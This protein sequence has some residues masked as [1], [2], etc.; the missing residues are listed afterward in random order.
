[1]Y[2]CTYTCGA[3]NASVRP[4]CLRVSHFCVKTCTDKSSLE[5]AS[6]LVHKPNCCFSFGPQAELECGFSPCCLEQ[7]VF[8]HGCRSPV[9]VSRRWLALEFGMLKNHKIISFF[10]LGRLRRT[11][12]PGNWVKG[13]YP[14]QGVDVSCIPSPLLG[15]HPLHP[16]SGVTFF[17]KLHCSLLL[18]Q[19]RAS[20]GE[21]L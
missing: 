11:E 19:Q 3:R 2:M 5:L 4:L 18:Q 13:I 15:T 21:G 17:W 16:H 20:F 7:S 9:R 10:N 1:M 8:H 6:S 12:L 14:K